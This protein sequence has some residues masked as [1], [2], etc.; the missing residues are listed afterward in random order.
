MTAAAVLEHLRGRGLVVIERRRAALVQCPAHDDRRPSLS[1]TEGREQR[2]LLHC[3]AGCRTTDILAAVDLR[4]N[5][6]F[7]EA[8]PP[9]PRAPRPRSPLEAARAEAIALGRRQAWARPGASERAHA[10][11]TIRAADRIRQHAKADDPDVW[12]RLAEAARATTEAENVLAEDD[13]A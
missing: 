7:P 13:P 5:D 1:V 8:P 6:L 9:A 4:L 3:R 11:D 10:A 12:E 2:V